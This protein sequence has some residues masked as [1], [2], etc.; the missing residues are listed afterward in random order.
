MDERAIHPSRHG[1]LCSDCRQLFDVVVEMRRTDSSGFSRMQRWRAN[2]LDRLNCSVCRI[3]HAAL[4]HKLRPDEL[5]K[6][7]ERNAR[8]KAQSFRNGRQDD[9]MIFYSSREDPIRGLRKPPSP[10]DHRI[11]ARINVQ[12]VIGTFH[13]KNSAIHSL[14]GLRSWSL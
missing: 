8:L 13:P 11:L 1:D 7:G 6:L 12:V 2:L 9:Q 4:R 3:V 10:F 5:G 14:R